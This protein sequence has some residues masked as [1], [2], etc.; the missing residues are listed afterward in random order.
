MVVLQQLQKF[1]FDHVQ[2]FIITVSST[3]M[4]LKIQLFYL[5]YWKAVGLQLSKIPTTLLYIHAIHTAM[6]AMMV[7]N[8]RQ[9]P[10]RS[11][12]GFNI[13]LLQ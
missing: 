2:P 7:W 1:V 12:V 11:G 13:L 4:Y 3:L 10:S 9:E 8:R 5:L 6:A